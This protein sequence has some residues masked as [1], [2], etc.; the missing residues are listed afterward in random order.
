MKVLVDIATIPDDQAVEIPGLGLCV[1]HEEKEL[2]DL[3]VAAYDDQRPEGA[4]FADDAD[5][6]GLLHVS[7]DPDADAEI[8][9]EAEADEGETAPEPETDPQDEPV[10]TEEQP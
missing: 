5:A 8:A 6:D 10:D 4:K 9:A 2:D 1:N 7:I 3:Q